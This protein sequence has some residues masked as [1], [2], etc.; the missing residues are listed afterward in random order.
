MF[1][2]LTDGILASFDVVSK[3]ARLDNFKVDGIP[4]ILANLLKNALMAENFTEQLDIPQFCLGGQICFTRFNANI[5]EG[6]IGA[7]ADIEF[8]PFRE[9]T[10]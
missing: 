6:F 1:P 5:R 2:K 7:D 4:D 10:S 8:R 9:E 3:I